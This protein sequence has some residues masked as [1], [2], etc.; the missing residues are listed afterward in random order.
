M[1]IYVDIDETIANRPER[2]CI[3]Y[4]ETIP[5]PENI[6]KINKLYDDG[7]KI[8]YWT[9]RGSG[10]GIDWQE[11]TE[12]QFEEW[13]V[14]YHELILKKPLYNV[15]IDDRNINAYE[16]FDNYNE[17]RDDFLEKVDDN[18]YDWQNENN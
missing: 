4:T 7:H 1:I 12:K 2:D 10:T 13:G 17:Y 11:I 6:A 18:L 16:F 5:L 3:D 15:F 8:V 9:A 14:K